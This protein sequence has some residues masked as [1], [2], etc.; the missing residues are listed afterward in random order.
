MSINLQEIIRQVAVTCVNNDTK[1][2]FN[3][4]A[5]LL[6]KQQKRE[7]KMEEDLRNDLA[8]IVNDNYGSD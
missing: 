7:D 3:L 5:T 4:L 2:A 6:D 8:E 1:R